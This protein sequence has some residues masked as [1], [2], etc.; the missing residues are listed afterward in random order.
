M[1]VEFN[2]TRTSV[3]DARLTE[4]IAYARSLGLPSVADRVPGRALNIIGRGPSVVRH[5]DELRR[6]DADNWACGT[7]WSWCRDNDI[8]ATFVAVDPS[9]AMAAPRYTAGVTRAIVAMQ[10]DPAV[11]DVLRG[12]DVSVIDCDQTEVGSTA[13]VIATVLGSAAGSVTRLYG[14]E[15]SYGETTHADEDQPQR[16]LM[17]VRCDGKVFRTNPQ[18]IIQTEEFCQ[19]FRICR[20]GVFRDCSGGLLGAMLATG[21]EW[22]L[23]RWDNAPRNVREMMEQAA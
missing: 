17:V 11:F 20:P 6:A 12:A 7:A 1:R 9:P 10:C 18:M 2:V 14:C 16:N 13:A 21:G 22:E 15:G 5:A 23:L 19:L 4:N 3:P 8:P